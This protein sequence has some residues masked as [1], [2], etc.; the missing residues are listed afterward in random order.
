MARA[1]TIL[2]SCATFRFGRGFFSVIANPRSLSYHQSPNSAIVDRTQP[3]KKRESEFCLL[4]RIP[5]E[6]KL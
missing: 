1:V 3:P 5:V 2:P 6:E 4:K